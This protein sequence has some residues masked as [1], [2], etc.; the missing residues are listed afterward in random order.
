MKHMKWDPYRNKRNGRLYSN[1]IILKKNN[2]YF[3]FHP[4]SEN[5]IKVAIFTSQ[6]RPRKLFPTAFEDLGLNVKNEVDMT[7][8]RRTPNGQ[9]NV[10][11]FALFLVNLTRNM[12][13]QMNSFNHII[14]KAELYRA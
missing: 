1:K 13:S 14:T 6:T 7:D 2:H 10:E 9:T 4:N 5:P 3:T 8:T 11:T 12:K